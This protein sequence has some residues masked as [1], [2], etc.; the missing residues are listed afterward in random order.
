VF[1]KYIGIILQNNHTRIS[2][3]RL[4]A[5]VSWFGCNFVC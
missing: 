1:L 5:D 2:R 4:R 3:N